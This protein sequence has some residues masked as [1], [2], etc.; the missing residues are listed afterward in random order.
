MNDKISVSP[1]IYYLVYSLLLAAITSIVPG[2]YGCLIGEKVGIIFVLYGCLVT[3]AILGFMAISR[4]SRPLTLA[5][6]VLLATIVW[7]VVPIVAAVPVTLALN[8]PFI[9]SWFEAV[10]GFTTTGLSMFSGSVDPDFHVYVPS[11]EELP[12]TV[13]LWRSFIQWLGGLGILVIFVALAL[14]AGL[15]PHLVGL[16]EGRYERLEPSLAHSLRRLFQT[17]AI[18]TI[19]ATIIFRLSGM[20]WFEA[21]NHAMTALST[22]GFSTKNTSIGYYNNVVLELAV[23]LAM[24][25]GTA[26]F[27]THYKVL[28]HF[29]LGALLR[30][31]ELRLLLALLTIETL[32]GTYFL[33]THGYMVLEALRLSFFQVVSVQ[34]T[35]GFQTMDL[36]KAPAAFK[37][38]LVAA[39]LIGGAILS[40]A[41]GM[42][43]YRFLVLLHTMW[44]AG[45][46]SV[47]VRGEI[48]SYKVGG[49]AINYDTFVQIMAVAFGYIAVWLI[50]TVCTMILLPKTPAIDAALE[51]ASAVGTVGV[52]VGL[53]G[54]NR[55][56]FYKLLYIGLMT[57]GRLEIIPYIACYRVIAEKLHSRRETRKDKPFTNREQILG[58][59][60]HKINI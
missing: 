44:W 41:G 19:A 12:K 14:S 36:E 30:D 31:C 37:L 26:N 35:T 45:R 50:G 15:P 1:V 58:R 56:V 49:K 3:L 20:T 24:V 29:D 25:W 38:L 22:G 9:D 32:L 17:Y 13:L 52:S 6:A 53:T 39:S 57:L 28:F 47:A 60:E 4:P 23:V 2:M 51:A 11:V 8:I 54:A 48:I 40:T 10:S 7:I 33:Y 55:H 59:Q 46:S 5:D 34:S 42:K 43:L 16:A 21:V 18:L 27:A